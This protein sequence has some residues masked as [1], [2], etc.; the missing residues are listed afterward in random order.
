M[1]LLWSCVFV[2]V[3]VVVVVFNT[4]WWL[5]L[6]WF[7][8][9]FLVKPFPLT[10]PAILYFLYHWDCSAQS[11]LFVQCWPGI[12]LV[13]CQENLCNFGAT[14]AATSYY[15]KINWFK[16]KIDEN[17]CYSDD[18]ALGFFLCNVAWSLLGNIAQGLCRCNVV[19]RVL[20]TTLNRIF[21]C[22]MLSGASW[23]LVPLEQHCTRFLPIQCC[24]KSMKT[25]L[26]KIFPAMLSRAS[27]TTWHKA[28]SVTLC[29]V[30]K[31][32]KTTLSIEKDFSYVMLSAASTTTLPRVFTFVMLS[33]EH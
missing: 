25:T 31:K 18:I 3:I 19:S 23:C 26:N 13:Q 32:I 21:S 22:A 11:C 7:H 20:A 4:F 30:P 8:F 10:F 28:F 12:F 29:N 9:V 15:Q 1:Q 16:I 33:Q 14:L 6:H 24:P 5:P 17:W 27:S 2:V